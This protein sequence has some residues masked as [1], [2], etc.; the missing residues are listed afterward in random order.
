MFFRVNDKLMI[1]EGVLCGDPSIDVIIDICAFALGFIY[2]SLNINSKCQ[3]IKDLD[4]SE[5][6]NKSVSDSGQMDINEQILNELKQLNSRISKVEEK[7]ESQDKGHISS[8]KSAKNAT[9]MASSS[10]VDADMVLPSLSGLR[11]S[12]HLQT[13]VNQRLQELQAI[14][15]QGKFKSQ[16]GV[17]M[18][19]YGVRGKFHGPTI[20]YSQVRVLVEH[21]MIVYQCPSGYRVLLP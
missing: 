3:H 20:L 15:M 13:Q 14:S 5:L 12:K 4:T 9:S 6:D 18:T 7:V 11:K 19:L 2:W 21:H 10:Q 17:Q 8:P 16:R 1:Q